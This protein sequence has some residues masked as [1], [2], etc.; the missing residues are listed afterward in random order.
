MFDRVRGDAAEGDQERG[1]LCYAGGLDDA[2]AAHRSR[3]DLVA[4]IF[5][6]YPGCAV[7]AVGLGERGCLMGL[8]DGALVEVA[9][10][11]PRGVVSTAGAG[12]ALFA[13]FLHSRRVPRSPAGTSTKWSQMMMVIR[14]PGLRRAGVIALAAAT[15]AIGAVTLAGPAYTANPP[16]SGSWAFTVDERY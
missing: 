16:A 9:T 13:S 12:D 4:K 7:A 8:A 1:S 14:R 15:A 6:R 10:V 3:D 2:D 11:A 5:H